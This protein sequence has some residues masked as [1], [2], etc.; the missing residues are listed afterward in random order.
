MHCILGLRSRR[1]LALAGMVRA[2]EVDRMV[3]GCSSSMQDEIRTR[4]LCN[5]AKEIECGLLGCY[6]PRIIASLIYRVL[7]C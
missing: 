2:L 7:Y 3:F 1:V 6:Y 5:R 4:G